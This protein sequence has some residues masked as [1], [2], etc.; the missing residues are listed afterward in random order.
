MDEA[1]YRYMRE[2]EDRHWWF[3]GRRQIVEQVL[4]TLPLPS[5]A[6]ILDAG[7][8]TGG[9]LAMLS[10]F[11]EVT[12][13]E[14]DHWAMAMAMARGPWRIESANFPGEVPEFSEKFDLIVLLDVLEHIAEDAATLRT[15]RGLLAPGG[16][17]IITV[18]AF[19]FLWSRHDVEHHHR[20]R[21]AAS[22]LRNLVQE[23][24]LRIQLLS[25][26]NAW[27]FPLI[28]LIRLAHRVFASRQVASDLKLPKNL[29]NRMLAAIF[30]SERHI[31]TRAYI[32][33]GVS[34]LAV[35]QNL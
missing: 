11:G 25:Y 6:R 14:R 30:S 2:V 15:L 20:R 5:S 1:I 33:F 21:Y 12:G 16:Y 26:Y 3:V 31:L 17:V 22:G 13:I 18:P 34:L 28:A 24:G 29:T 8:G 9:N 27:L 7:C 10:S 19:Q 35:A 32:P 4:K 23:S